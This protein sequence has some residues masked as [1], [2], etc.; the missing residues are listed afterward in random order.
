MPVSFIEWVHRDTLTANNYNPNH[1]FSPEMEL[2]RTSLLRD[3]WTLPLVVREN[4]EIVDGFHRWTLSGDKKVYEM[5]D[6]FV[7]V[8][9]LKNKSEAEQIASTI[10]YNRARG[11][12]H[13]LKMSDI[14]I[15]LKNNKHVPDAEI[16]EALGMELTEVTL[17]YERGS[18][19]KRAGKEEFGKAWKPSGKRNGNK[20]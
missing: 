20:K 7:P 6:G 17:L 9:R 15:D 8:V 14:V 10:R 12:H 1:V 3:G 16:A 19:L 18:M 5:T 13:V 4:N 11:V 2:L